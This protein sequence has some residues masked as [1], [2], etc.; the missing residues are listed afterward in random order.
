MNIFLGMKILW[1]FLWGY[2]KIGLVLGVISMYLHI[3]GYYKNS[4]TMGYEGPP[5]SGSAHGSLGA[6]N[7]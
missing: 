6:V 1:I 7:K 5:T 4:I 2:P 3:G